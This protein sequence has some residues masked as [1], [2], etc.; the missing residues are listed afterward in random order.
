MRFNKAEYKV[1]HL[2]QGNTRY[3]N[4]PGDERFES[5]PAEKDLGLLVEEY[6]DMTH[7]CALTA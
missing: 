4:M 2:G 3:Q 1:L 6:L 7:Q 5:S